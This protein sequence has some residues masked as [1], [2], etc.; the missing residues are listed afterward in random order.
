MQD[1]YAGDVGDFGKFALLRALSRG[2]RWCIRRYRTEGAGEANNDG[3]HLAYLRE[4]ERF[5]GLDDVVFTRLRDF[6]ADVAAR[7]CQRSIESL[8]GLGLV[9][10]N[11]IS[12]S[13]SLPFGTGGTNDVGQKIWWQQ[14]RELL[15]PL[16]PDNGLER[17][18]LTNKRAARSELSALRK[19]GRV[20]LL[21]HHQT[22]HKG[23]R[24]PRRPTSPRG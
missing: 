10:P 13:G 11:T 4:P 6:I 15:R 14:W 23:E 22:R 17:Q 18:A 1:R 16:D 5:E 2:R 7:R 12:P 9:P 21:Y 24:K 3:Q 19:A 8:E 20:L